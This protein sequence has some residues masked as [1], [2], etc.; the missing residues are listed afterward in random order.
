MT[1]LESLELTKR[2]VVSR[3]TQFYDP[4]SMEFPVTVS[5]KILF[6]DINEARVG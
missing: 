6:Q 5:F 2:R 3:A 1:A 4:L